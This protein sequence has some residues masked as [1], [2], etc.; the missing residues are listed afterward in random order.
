M[1]GTTRGRLTVTARGLP[2]FRVRLYRIQP[3][4]LNHLITQSSGDFAHL[5]VRGYS[6]NE[7]NIS[8][9]FTEVRKL[10][11]SKPKQAQY[12]AVD[13][14]PYLKAGGEQRGMYFVAVEAWD[15]ATNTAI[16]HYTRSNDPPPEAEEESEQGEDY[17][18]VDREEDGDNGDEG[19]EEG[20]YEGERDSE[21]DSGWGQLEDRRFV[22]LTD[23]GVIDKLDAQQNHWVFVQSFRTGNPV[24]ATVEVLAK[25]GTIVMKRSTDA[26][27][28][29]NG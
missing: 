6:F 18:A 21:E 19:E 5:S 3:K 27:N 2:G 16:T 25:N 28:E 7:E 10:D 26:S 11:A 1:R 15:P 9:L 13:F 4:D 14:A 24:S 12:A 22:L 23:L 20:E 8:E 29:W 17:E